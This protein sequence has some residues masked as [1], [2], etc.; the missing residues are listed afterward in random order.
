MRMAAVMEQRLN[1]T[2]RAAEELHAL[3]ARHDRLLVLVGE[4]L[5]TNERLRLKVAQME[6]LT[7]SRWAGTG[8]RQ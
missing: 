1:E 5:E 7:G 6:A 8:A 2:G 4:L 3:Q